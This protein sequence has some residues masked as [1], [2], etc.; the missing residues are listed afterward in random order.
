MGNR[1]TLVIAGLV[2]ALNGIGGLAFGDVYTLGTCPV[3]RQKLG[4]MG[5]P[6]VKTYDGREVR[7]CC[8]GC[9]AKFEANQAKYSEKINAQTTK[10]QKPFYPLTTCIVSGQKL[11]GNMGPAVEYVYKNRLVRFCCKGCI[12]TF[13]KEPAKY[14]SEL[15]KAV[16]SKQKEAYPVQVCV[17]SGEKLGGNMGKP[18]DHVVGNRLVRLCCKACIKK[19]E[20]DPVKYLSRL[21]KALAV[22]SA[23]EREK[24]KAPGTAPM[25][26]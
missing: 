20:K 24:V 14:L 5:A 25:T 8:G 26:R 17:V 23:D 6:L 10:Q 15:D 12:N 9:P 13:E 21:D 22:K 2:L 18:V 3:S 11:G 19:L 4:S 1:K 16:I 7:F